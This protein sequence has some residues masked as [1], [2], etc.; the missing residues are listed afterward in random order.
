MRNVRGILFVD[1]VRMIKRQLADWRRYV[2]P[3]DLPF[4]ETRIEPDQWYPMASFE[5][6]GLL[7]LRDIVGTETDS[8]RLWGRTQVEAILQF[9]PD[10]KTEGDPADAIKRFCDFLHG[11]F[12]FKAVALEHLEPTA[13][14]IRIAYGMGPVAESAACWQ[15]V[16]FFEALV[17]ASGGGAVRCRMVAP[18]LFELRWSAPVQLAAAPAA[19]SP[20]KV[21]V[22]DDERLV[23][24]AMERI[25]AS[26]AD[27]TVVVSPAEA[28]R[29]L[30][31]ERFD[32]VL[33][34]YNMRERD[35]L[36]LL[37]EVAKRWPHVKRVL[38]SADM[39]IAATEYKQ[40]GLIH[41]LI[42]KPAALDVL[43]VAISPL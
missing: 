24:V 11:L 41:E 27:V 15:T 33:S 1:Y 31:H 19:H 30:E 14:T 16:G 10:L 35:G 26:V 5:R 38:Q 37:E 17:T 4:F 9:L 12:D 6:L 36:S 2:D 20:P 21:L 32:T 13:T 7:I 28:L 8:V 22:V 42:D 18:E 40:R 34:D 29:R 39:P 43:R 25:L 23:L 3:A